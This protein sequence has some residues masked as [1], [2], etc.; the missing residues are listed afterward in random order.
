M[1]SRAK[2]PQEVVSDGGGLFAG[3]MERN[4]RIP[5]LLGQVASCSGGGERRGS[6]GF[7]S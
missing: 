3:R 6:D 7:H 2:T 4:E 1:P 5:S